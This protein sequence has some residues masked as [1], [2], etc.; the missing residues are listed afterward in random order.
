LKKSGPPSTVVTCAALKEKIEGN[1]FVISYFGDES[2][3]LY[4]DAHVPYA[5][6]EDKIVFVHNNEADCAKE[7]GSAMPGLVF[8]RKFET[9]TNNYEGAAD[10]DSV[11]EFVKPLMVPTVFEF[12]EDEIEAVFGQ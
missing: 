7:Y 5:N 4:T 9:V 3:A 11:I 8:H 10:K 12:T 6:Q 2:N 1:K